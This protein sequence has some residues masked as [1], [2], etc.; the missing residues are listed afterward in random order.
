M[1]ATIDVPV[2]QAKLL[3][4]TEAVELLASK[5]KRIARRLWPSNE[6]RI[7]EDLVQEMNLAC[8][9]VSVPMTAK[10]FTAVAISRAIDYLDRE[11]RH[12]RLTMMAPDKLALLSDRQQ[13]RRLKSAPT[14]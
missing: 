1:N 13:A 11:E 12:E 3:T 2:K 9:K 4:S 5:F 10:T 6:R 7:K 14:R 8:L